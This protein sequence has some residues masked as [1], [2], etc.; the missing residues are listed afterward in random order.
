MERIKIVAEKLNKTERILSG[1]L[2]ISSVFQNPDKYYD[3]ID[4]VAGWIKSI[5]KQKNMI[6]IDLTDGSCNTN[7]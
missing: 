4:T 1:V 5:K 3:T 6:F 2:K 7:L